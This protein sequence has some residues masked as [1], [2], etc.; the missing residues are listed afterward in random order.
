MPES[1]SPGVGE[2]CPQTLLSR[3]GRPS[4]LC[5]RV[6]RSE[7]ARRRFPLLVPAVASRVRSPRSAV[8]RRS[9]TEQ[10]CHTL[11]GPCLDQRSGRVSGRRPPGRTDSARVRR[12]PWK[13]G[14]HNRFAG[15]PEPMVWRPSGEFRFMVWTQ[16]RIRSRLSLRRHRPGLEQ[17]DER[18][19]LST[20]AGTSLPHSAASHH[21]AAAL[22]VHIPARQPLHDHAISPVNHDQG[23]HGA[24]QLSPRHPSSGRPARS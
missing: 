7:A 16:N 17:L 6:S 4:I 22:R 8:G 9:R 11:C 18:C 14:V 24:Y 19:L 21:H 3:A 5:A 15:R 13:G 1:P 23:Q 20:G 12:T 2:E 10:P